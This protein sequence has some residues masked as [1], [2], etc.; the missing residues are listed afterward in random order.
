MPRKPKSKR[1]NKGIVLIKKAN[2]LIESRYKFD[3]WET[4]VFLSVLAQIRRDDK[5]LEVYRIHYKD[6]IKTF[7]LKSGDSYH[8]LRD[9]A[10]SL[11]GKSFFV[12]YEKNGVFREKQYHILR[13][14]DYLKEGQEGASLDNHEYIDVV[15]EQQMK[16]LLLEL[17]KNFTAYDLRNI[18]KLG[19]YPVRVYELLKQYE[20]IGART[21]K[22][23]EMKRMFELTDQYRLFADFFRWVVKPAVKE[24]NKHTDL[25]ITQVDKLKEGRRVV[26]LRFAF[27]TKMEEE[28]QSE[29]AP[30]PLGSS[31]SADL[32]LSTPLEETEKDRLFKALQGDVVSRFGVTPSVFL[33]L[34]EVYE[35]EQIR[36]A[37]R[38]TNRAKYKQQIKSNVAGFFIQALKQGYTDPKEE[39]EKKQR[40]E[41][42]AAARKEKQTRRQQEKAKRL[43]QRIKEVTAEQTDI[44]ERA[45]A[46]LR[47]NHIVKMLI[48]KK[49]TAL[50]RSLNIEDYRQDKVLREFVKGKI[51]ELAGDRFADILQEFGE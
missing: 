34:L 14:I 39:L 1:T 35:E 49:E 26:A 33:K 9:A 4:R 8:L 47:E 5:E 21:L 37:I 31:S 46:Q 22:V 45:I 20:R 27:H 41:Q 50:N 32:E 11:M 12:K 25:T 13:E 7:G 43:N 3:I 38:I 44:T 17:Q 40:K 24:I 19:V 18:V 51:V 36:Q 16:P 30:K 28:A 23:Q 42:K 2:N 48:E 15:V 10:K 6:V 29:S